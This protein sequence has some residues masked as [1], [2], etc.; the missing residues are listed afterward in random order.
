MIDLDL[1][2]NCF[3][4]LQ[5]SQWEIIWAR[6]SRYILRCPRCRAFHSWAPG[7][8]LWIGPG[9]GGSGGARLEE[10]RCAFY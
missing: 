6:D 5:P 2:I 7:T 4:D 10:K 9:K 8:G 1:C 3:L